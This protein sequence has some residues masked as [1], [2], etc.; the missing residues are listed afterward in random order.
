M[1]AQQLTVKSA[2]AKAVDLEWTGGAPAASLERSSGQSYQK[3][4]PGA[5]GHYTDQKIEP[6]GIYKYRLNTAGKF[7]NVVTVGPPPDGVTNSAPAP[8]GSVL[9]HYGSAS[10]MALDE[11]GDP[12]IAFEWFDPNGDG[13]SSDTE[14]RFVRWDRASYKWASPVRVLVTGEMSDANANPF[15]IACDR[16]TGTLA[17]LS[18][19]GDDLIYALSTDRGV[20]WRTTPGPK[21]TGS[22]RATSLVINSGQVHAAAMG[23]ND[24]FYF[25]GS[26]S[27]VSSWKAQTLPTGSGWTVRPT[28]IPLALDASGK[29]AMAFLENQADGDQHRYV[30]WRPGNSDPVAVATT[31]QWMDGPNVALTYGNNKFGVLFAIPMD[32]KDS[33]H[34]VFYT[35]SSDGSS[36]SSPAKLP[37]DGPRGTNPPL[38]VA[39]DSKGNLTA[40]FGSNVGSGGTTC[41]FPAVS[42][43]TDGTNWKTCG[44]GKSAGARF[45]AQ[46]PTLHVIEAGNDK[47]YIVW[48]QPDDNKYGAGVLVWHGR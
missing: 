26:M 39:I 47:T 14:I 25:N 15:G 2:T 10:S 21:I 13:D 16:D 9:E 1:Q 17:V 41:D 48:Q 3:V 18:Q 6:F 36:W 45:N 38:E 7:S 40:V 8:K 20:T 5:D 37:I 11:N 34:D 31:N 23:N 46:P 33:D 42:R 19:K 29:P 35:Q 22:L 30:F 4:A 24:A 43:S 28:N 27:D 32:P 44:L 12:V